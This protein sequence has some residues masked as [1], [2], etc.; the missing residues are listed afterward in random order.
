LIKFVIAPW[1]AFISIICANP[2][3]ALTGDLNCDGT[4]DFSDFF[5][6]SDNFN[7]TG[8][9]GS[10]CAT[11]VGDFDCDGT[12][13]FSDFFVF[14]DNFGKEGAVGPECGAVADGTEEGN[15]DSAATDFHTPQTLAQILAT[16]R[17]VAW[18]PH[19]ESLTNLSRLSLG[20]KGTQDVLVID[21]NDNDYAAALTVESNMA[22][23]QTHTNDAL[24]KAM[25]K[26]IEVGIDTYMLVSTK[27]SNYAVDVVTIGDVQTLVMRDYRS[28]FMDTS[29]AAF[30][31]F[32]F[33]ASGD[34]THIA[35]TNRHTYSVLAGGFVLDE[36]WTS[37]NVAI[38]G[39]S[40]IL[41]TQ[42]GTAFTAF[43]LY[44]PILDQDIPFDFN[45]TKIERVSN[46]EFQ[47]T[48]DGSDRLAGSIRDVLD[49]YKDQVAAVGLD[50]ATTVA[51]NTMLSTIESALEAEGAAM[52]YPVA[53]YQTVRASM[54]V[55]TVQVSDN[56]DAVIG[57]NSIPYVYFTNETD[58]DGTH[59][60]FMVI[61]SYGVT[62]GMTH[63]WD[64]P[65]PPGDGTPGTGYAEQTV[66][67]NAGGQ[68]YFAKI[69]IRDYGQIETLTQ[70]TMVNDLA[71]DVPGAV[72]FTHLNYASTSATGIAI[73]GVVVYPTLNNTLNVSAS[74]GEISS[75]GI[76]S[77]RGLGVHYH[78]DSHSATQSGL[79]LYNAADYEGYSHP[80]IISFGFDGVAG[81]GKYMD[82]DTT[83]DG[84]AQGLD[85]WG[86][87]TH[88]VY[89][90][91]YHSE[92]A[93]NT[94]EVGGPDGGNVP[95]TAHMLPPK[96][97]WRGRINDIPEFWDGS[98]PAYGGRPGQYQGLEAR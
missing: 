55:R 11:L 86:G 48:W 70:N 24:V 49:A 33:T 18:T 60:P 10:E 57:K 34:E 98:A 32:T 89:G 85:D 36:S 15:E 20:I 59:H 46:D 1:L 7:T 3:Q 37:L 19:T 42:A 88:D 4:V 87:H 63:L 72:E 79:N 90:Y 44:M 39:S 22:A 17:S 73:D 95:Y 97:A 76:H 30:L 82:G 53:F 45:P 75:V 92:T 8:E 23:S 16:T 27:H 35:A 68:A 25:F 52:R 29:T 21:D 26:L 12:V 71:S 28:F 81:Y 58:T 56:F 51:A 96:G 40:A 31:T 83:S 65:R 77:G 94:A 43:S 50:D 5:V 2:L 47:A 62:E 6:F 9:T 67:R 74:A 61:A 84:V 54:L 93:G 66:T 69:P 38:D 80:P 14:S 64:V 78:A 91:H 41:T 13:D